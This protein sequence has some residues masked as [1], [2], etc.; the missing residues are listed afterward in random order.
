MKDL[1]KETNLI[2]GNVERSQQLSVSKNNE[3]ELEF[4]NNTQN[5]KNG[6]SYCDFIL[7]P[8]TNYI[9]HVQLW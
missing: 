2:L 5:D 3:S 6:L 7:N 4:K 9:V 1:L 8:S